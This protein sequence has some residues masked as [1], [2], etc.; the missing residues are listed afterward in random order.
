[1]R[2][3]SLTL[4][5]ALAAYGCE[6]LDLGTSPTP[7]APPAVADPDVDATE[8][9]PAEGEHRPRV[10]AR[11]PP[12]A[13]PVPLFED[14][15][16]ER[17][18]DAATAS[19]EGFLLLDLG[20]EWTPYLFTEQSNPGEERIEHAYRETYLALARGE[21]PSD[22]HG[23]RAERD[24][25]LELYGIMPTLGLLRERFRRVRDLE[26]REDLD[27]APLEAFDG[28]IRYTNNGAAR[29]SA[30][31]FVVV[32]RAVA[33]YVARQH[34]ADESALDEGRLDD[35][36][37]RTLREFR[38]NAPRVRA[39]RATQA[40]LECEGYFEGKG[41]YI[42][43]GLDWPTHE[44][45]A[46]FERRH[47]LFGWGFIGNDTLERL[48][49][50][51]LELE[52]QAVIRILTERAVHSLGVLEDGSAEGSTYRAADNTDTPIPNLEEQ[53]RDA[54]VQALGLT[55]PEATLDFLEGLGEL[56]PGDERMVAIHA[57][58]LPPYYSSDMNIRIEIDRGDVWYEF[59]YDEEGRER[60]QPVQRRPRTSVIV[61]YR[62][63]DIRVARFGTT[64]GGWRTEEIDGSIWW[65]YKNS[66]VGPRVWENI[67]SA[68]VWMPPPSTPSRDL[69]TRVP[70]RSGA[71]AYRVNLHE[72]GPSYASAYGLV[73]AYHRMYS[74]DDD[75]NITLRG[76]EGIRSHGSVDYMSIMRRHSHGCHRLHNHIAVRLM[77]W[78]LEHR[79]HTRVG[80]QQTAFH[81]AIEH[82]GHTYQL[83]IERGG[84]VFQLEHP[85][86]VN[87]LE[88]RIRGSRAT[89]IETPLPR[90]DAELGAYV[91]PE[92]AAFTISRTG[93]MTPF[94]LPDAGL[95]IPDGGVAVA[96]TIVNPF[97]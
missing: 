23:A 79:N 73:A 76:D 42:S 12:L 82:D 27:L 17:E 15:A 54:L 69:V 95:P 3:L 44:A 29:T 22:H 56:S 87:V 65:R 43:G 74:E 30:R 61:R 31:R 19:E 47:R 81:R 41:D 50:S 11:P 9:P 86:R 75:G 46:E 5:L 80:H 71:D 32:E 70:G 4:L 18:I 48:R 83:D 16:T 88:G 67:V 51:P 26:C 20:E 72:T 14:G 45:L 39:I 10:D 28:F 91:N 13:H 97:E 6:E 57:P 37:Q 59:P 64:V 93:V 62:G 34:V 94:A 36:E 90:Y 92:G 49:M 89:P 63:Q 52:R 21:F 2:R 35:R 55:T 66:P 68:P 96:P 24:K 1:M 60:S 40:R 77:S 84:Y 7:E 33:D 58:E 25:Y 8:P 53:T 85:I 78:V 38:E